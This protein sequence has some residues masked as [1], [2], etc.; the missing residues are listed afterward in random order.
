MVDITFAP[1]NEKKPFGDGTPVAGDNI[2]FSQER[3]EAIKAV[4]ARRATAEQTLLVHD[5]D[6]IIQEAIE[7][8]GEK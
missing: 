5:T 1:Y 2:P 8:R 3:W 6:R 4:K 7:L